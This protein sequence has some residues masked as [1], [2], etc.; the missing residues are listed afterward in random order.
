MPKFKVRV[1]KI[2][3]AQNTVEIE[4]DDM[5]EARVKA[6]ESAGNYDYTEYDA[7]HEVDTVTEIKNPKKYF[8]TLQADG[9]YSIFTDTN[10]ESMADE[11]L[12]K[13]DITSDVEACDY[14]LSVLHGTYWLYV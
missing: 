7:N 10:M 5:F 2:S 1:I 4:A 9:L 13:H 6:Y 11:T 12:I 14:V 3:Y 8:I